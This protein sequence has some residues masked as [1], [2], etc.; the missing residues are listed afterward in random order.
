MSINRVNW[1]NKFSVTIQDFHINDHMRGT[2]GVTQTRTLTPTTKCNVTIKMKEEAKIRTRNHL[3]R[4]L[5]EKKEGTNL[6]V[7]YAAI[8]I[9]S[10]ERN[11]YRCIC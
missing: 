1:L 2:P 5:N 3:H 4:M 9:K 7:Q 11:L 10:G 8:P 6:S